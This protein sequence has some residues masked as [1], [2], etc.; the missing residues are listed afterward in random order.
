MKDASQ[1]CVPGCQEWAGQG[2]WFLVLLIHRAHSSSMPSGPRVGFRGFPLD[3]FLSLPNQPPAP[4]CWSVLSK[5]GGHTEPIMGNVARR[6]PVGLAM[7][8]TDSGIFSLELNQ[9]WAL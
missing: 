1:G 5:S 4:P 8:R 6:V 7:G 9:I 3:A 2:R